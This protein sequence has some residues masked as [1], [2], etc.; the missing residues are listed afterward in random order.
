M[1]EGQ[2][3]LYAEPKTD[4][5]SVVRTVDAR[6]TMLRVAEIGA[7][8]FVWSAQDGFAFVLNQFRQVF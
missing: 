2:T 4:A 3:T 7:F 6:T 5:Q 1:I 8:T